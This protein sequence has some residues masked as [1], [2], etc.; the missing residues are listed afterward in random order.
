MVKLR[1]DFI[2]VVKRRR[3]RLDFIEVAIPFIYLLLEGVQLITCFFLWV[4]HTLIL[5]N[6]TIENYNHLMFDLLMLQ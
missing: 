1:I 5:E 2:E 3:L 6:L 4:D